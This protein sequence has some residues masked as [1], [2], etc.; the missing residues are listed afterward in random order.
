MRK[1]LNVNGITQTNLP[2]E[3]GKTFISFRNLFKIVNFTFCFVSNHIFSSFMKHYQALLSGGSCI[4]VGQIFT[5]KGRRAYI[6][7]G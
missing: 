1:I 2:F 4:L 7:E 6:Y 3:T 5:V